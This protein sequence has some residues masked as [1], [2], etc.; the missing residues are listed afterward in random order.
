MG[1]NPTR[2]AVYPTY[3]DLL[4]YNNIRIHMI[5][6]DNTR[7]ES[8]P[9]DPSLMDLCRANLGNFLSVSEIVLDK[10]FP[11]YVL[12]YDIRILPDP[13]PDGLAN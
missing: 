11:K 6:A 13:D 12:L 9:L 10:E 2:M 5:Q 4:A 7:V 8:N 3:P 1:L